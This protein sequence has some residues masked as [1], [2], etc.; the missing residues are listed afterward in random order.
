MKTETIAEHFNRYAPLRESWARRSQFYH[1]AIRKFMAYHIPPGSTVLDVG[2]GMGET[3]A[4]L[5]GRRT[6][7]I[8]ISTK[9]VDLARQKFPG[10]EF[11]VADAQALPSVEP[12]E[13]VILADTIGYLPDVQ[14]AFEE[15]RKVTT[16]SSRLIITY[17]N[18]LWQPILKLLEI[19]QLRMPQPELNWLPLQDIQNLLYLAGFE[20][21]KKGYQ[22]LL[23]MDIPVL[24][25]LVN[26]VFARLPWI[27]NL[28]LVE[29]V[30]AKPRTKSKDPKQISCSVIVPCRNEKDNIADAVTRTAPMGRE[31]EII[32][33]DGAS[34]DGTLEEIQRMQKEYP[35]RK[36]RLI[37]QH[38]PKG[39]YD[40]VKMGFE[41]AQGDLLMI[42]DADLTVPP[43]DLSKFF[44]AY[45]EGKGEFISGSRLVYPMEKQAM[46]FL[47]LLG[48][49]FFGMAFSFLLDQR[50][51]DTLCGTKVVSRANY[52]KIK[53]GRVYFG[54]F[55]PF[56]DF[57]LLFGASKLNLKIVEL[58]IRYRERVYGTTKIRRFAHGWLLLKMCWVAMRKLKF[59]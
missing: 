20:V 56:G 19:F 15:V 51:T 13:F 3:L 23:P 36:I 24:T 5:K 28:C 59:V 50:F 42:L 14:K 43:E 40:A 30:I 26:R 10:V 2:C 44:A 17:Y 46:R 7:G 29:W 21:V 35:A 1:D 8:D 11:R 27:R 52:Q 32:F 9:L 49:K 39:K 22:I 57:D 54:D 18:Y 58:P 4:S 47:N 16:D 6:L 38:D 55:D 53:E 41:A 31:T 45:V 12:F 48:N 33:V 37:Q 25:P 34:T